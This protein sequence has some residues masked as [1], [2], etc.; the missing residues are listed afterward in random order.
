MS[1]FGY[2]FSAFVLENGPF[3]T[4]FKSREEYSG[5]SLKTVYLKLKW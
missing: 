2:C 4:F 5:N 1:E 3:K